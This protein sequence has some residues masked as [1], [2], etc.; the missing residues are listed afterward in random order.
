MIVC[1]SQNADYAREINVQQAESIAEAA[2]TFYDKYNLIGCR[3]LNLNVSALCI[4]TTTQ[5][6]VINVFTKF[7]PL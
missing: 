1:L 5:I 2:V 3:V 4:I 6:H 7:K